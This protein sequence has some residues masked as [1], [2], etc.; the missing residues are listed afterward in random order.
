[1]TT[2]NNNILLI[3]PYLEKGLGI[4]QLANHLSKN[5]FNTTV[6]FFKELQSLFE[7]K[8]ITEKELSLLKEIIEAKN[9]LFVG[10]SIHSSLVIYEIKELISF[11]KKNIKSPFVIGG[12]YA[13]IEPKECAKHCDIVIKGEGEFAL[14]EFAN[15]LKNGKETN[16]IPNLCYFNENKEY[17]ENELRPFAKNLDNISSTSICKNVYFIENNEVSEG[18][19]QLKTSFYEISASRGCPFNC[20]FCC[21][22][23]MRRIYQDKGQYLRFRSVESIMNELNEAIRKNPK[24]EV[25]RFWDEVFSNDKKW[26]SEF[27]KRY[28]SE[29][30]L[31]FHAWGHPSMVKD[32]IIKMLRFAGLQRIVVGFQS[33]SP[34]V[35][36]NIFKR[37]E[38]NEQII[39]T[40]KILSKYKIPE[41]YYDL[42]ICHPWRLLKNL[43]KLFI[44]V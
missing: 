14:V 44:F 3:M 12:V 37:P 35:R 22:A 18:D 23:N 8:E 13:S 38:T 2:A 30:G 20:S 28:R 5:G 36:N 31:P 29:I 16:N 25:I 6:V 33:G 7:N 34:N 10:L 41:I 11:L 43:K 21:S 9:Y 27:V 4:R 26:V 17:V 24:I 15:A 40:S 1:M 42:M 19:P 39:Q 32:E